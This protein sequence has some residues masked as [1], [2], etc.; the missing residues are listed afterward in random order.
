ML[1]HRLEV[2]ALALRDP[3]QRASNISEIAYRWGFNDLSYFNKAFRARFDMTPGEWR[4]ELQ[5]AA[6][7]PDEGALAV[8]ASGTK[9]PGPEQRDQQIEIPF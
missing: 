5:V 1:D 8:G 9:W 3:R 4:S 6:N 2:C 7:A